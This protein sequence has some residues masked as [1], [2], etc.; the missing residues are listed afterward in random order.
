VISLLSNACY[1][2]YPRHILSFDNVRTGGTTD[3]QRT[4]LG[5][6]EGKGLLARHVDMEGKKLIFKTEDEGSGFDM[7]M[8]WDF[9]NA[10]MKNL[11]S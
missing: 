2:N 1:I 7:G 3:A 5:K 10:V 11:I 8:E 9:V 6:P 4:F